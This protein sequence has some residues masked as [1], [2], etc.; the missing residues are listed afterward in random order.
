MDSRA[1]ARAPS[2]RDTR[3]FN[4][5]SDRPAQPRR[6]IV[7]HPGRAV[8]MKSQGD[9]SAAG[10][11]VRTRGPPGSVGR[12]ASEH[13]AV[14]ILAGQPQNSSRRAA[15]RSRGGRGGTGSRK[16]S[17]EAVAMER[18]TTP[19]NARA[20]EDG[21]PQAGRAGRRGERANAQP[22]FWLDDPRPRRSDRSLSSARRARLDDHQ[23]G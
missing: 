9:T 23:E 10:S 16:P 14:A 8:T 18:D 1:E 3:R 22:L 20:G 21:I 13:S 15:T 11:R 7:Q 17:I 12:M 2:Q 6:G 5:Y 19:A 4:R